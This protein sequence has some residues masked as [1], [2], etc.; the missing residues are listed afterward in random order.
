MQY[1]KN[2]YDVAIIGGGIG[3]IMAAHRL[4]EKAPA[5]KICILEKGKD[6][7]D[8]VCPIITK[9]AKACVKWKGWRARAPFRTENTSS[10]PNMADG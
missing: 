9:Q 1:Y 10:P 3:G 6:L 4:S 2:R 7:L 8:R 5:L